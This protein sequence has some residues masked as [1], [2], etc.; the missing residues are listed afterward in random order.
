MEKQERI[1]ERKEWIKEWEE[2]K[3][4]GERRKYWRVWR[5][6][7]GRRW[8]RWKSRGGMKGNKPRRRKNKDEIIT[9]DGY[10]KE[11]QRKKRASSTGGSNA[12]PLRGV[13]PN[14]VASKPIDCSP[15]ETLLD[16][17]GTYNAAP[18]CF[19]TDKETDMDPGYEM[20]PEALDNMELSKG[21][22]T[23]NEGEMG[24]FKEER[25]KEILKQVKIGK[26]LTGGEQAEVE[27][28]LREHTDCFPLSVS[29][30]W[31]IEGAVHRLKILDDT[32]FQKKVHQKTVD[33]TTA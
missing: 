26:G 30:V 8:W 18:V 7:A 2:L 31:H 10:I 16:P 27:K 15:V 13:L 29:E 19:I 32:K 22:F 14:N 33:A 23:R 1:L 17:I 20:I 25:V 28:L 21:V 9:L 3:R 4:K 12:P 24:A 6:T 5:G 11:Q